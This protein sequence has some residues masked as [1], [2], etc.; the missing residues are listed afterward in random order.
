MATRDVNVDWSNIDYPRFEM[1]AGV[2][3]VPYAL[4]CAL[5]PP[6]R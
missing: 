6:R 5:F 3:S 1:I 4:R 2:L